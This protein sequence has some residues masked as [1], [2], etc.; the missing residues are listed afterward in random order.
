MSGCGGLPGRGRSWSI[1]TFSFRIFS[2]DGL[3]GRDLNGIFRC[4]PF[5][6]ISKDRINV[7]TQFYG[8]WD[9]DTEN[10]PRNGLYG[11]NYTIRSGRIQ[12]KLTNKKIIRNLRVWLSLLL[13]RILSFSILSQIQEKQFNSNGMP[14]WVRINPLSG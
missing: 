9:L 8:L 2:S 3:S 7:S 13:K 1:R 5:K 6:T 14:F 4:W 11:I 12:S 10:F